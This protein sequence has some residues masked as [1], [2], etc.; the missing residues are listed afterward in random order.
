MTSSPR[1]VSR[2]LAG[3]SGFAFPEWRGTFYPPKLPPGGM[4]AHY[5]AHLPTVELN[6]SFYRT[7]S[8]ATVARWAAAVP[9]S[10]RFATKAHRRITHEKRLRGAEEELRLLHDRLQGLGPTLGPVLFQLPPFLRYDLPLLEDFLAAL[11]PLPQVAVEFRHP[12]WFTE[13]TY[14]LL[15]RRGAAL[16]VAED[17]QSCDPLVATA[18]FGYY[19][20]HR[21][22]YTEEQILAWA[23]RLRASP[24]GLAYCYFTHE[25]GPESVAYAR[26]LMEAVESL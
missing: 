15:R 21:L 13:G 20:L 6:V 9:P 26:R 8:Q 14:D 4:L 16:V 10:F 18:G 23:H 17:D 19:R 25:T 22:G 1:P 2:V 12:T 3:T 24:S 7:P 11:P 5:A